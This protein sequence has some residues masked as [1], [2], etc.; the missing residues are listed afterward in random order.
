MIVDAPQYIATTIATTIAA[1][2]AIA[3]AWV[4]P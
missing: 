3:M 2:K 1:A 4:Y